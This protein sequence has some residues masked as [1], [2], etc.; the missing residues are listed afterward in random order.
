LQLALV[1]LSSGC[2]TAPGKPASNLEVSS[3]EQVLN[4]ASLYGQNCAACHGEHGRYGA[5]ISLA[6]PVYLA[7][8][9]QDDLHRIVSAGVPGTLMPPFGKSSGGMLTDQQ[10]SVLAREMIASWSKPS[11]LNGQTPPPYIGHLQGD[12]QNGQKAFTTY[13]A[14]CHG[15]DG[16]GVSDNRIKT[17]S[18][19][20]PAYLSLISEQG[21]RSIIIAGNPDQGMPDWRSYPA[22]TPATPKPAPIT[23]REIADIVAWLCAHRV[24]TPGQPYP[25]LK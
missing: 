19:V 10:V 23:D 7:T 6:N 3:P 21:L 12:A 14:R 11:L 5:A 17:G 16:K 1:I 15:N 20:D 18:L 25:E 2:G 8:V 13:C 4:F 9:T 22:A 24:R